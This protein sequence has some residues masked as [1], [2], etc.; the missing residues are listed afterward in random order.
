MAIS[1]I[2]IAPSAGPGKAVIVTDRIADTIVS[3]SS[4]KGG[5]SALVTIDLAPT[6]VVLATHAPRI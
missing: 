5:G 3:L 1:S 6:P 4:F 2:D